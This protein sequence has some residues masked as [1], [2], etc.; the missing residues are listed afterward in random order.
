MRTFFAVLFCFSFHL[1]SAQTYKTENGEVQFL[2]DAPIEKF[3]GKSSK[4]TGRIDAATDTVDFFIDLTTLK[5]GVSLRD[6]HM[7]ENYLE[8]KKF[9]FAEFYGI[10]L[11]KPDY[12]K[13]EKQPV[14]VKGRFTIHGVSKEMTIDGFVTPQKDGLL[15]EAA[16]TVKLSDHGIPIPSIVIRKLSELQEVSMKT[17]LKPSK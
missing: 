10:L 6:E 8:T 5:T 2:S 15:V 17:L 4:L 1:A 14:K 3:T 16:W 9:P 7:R 12:A 13:L 11:T